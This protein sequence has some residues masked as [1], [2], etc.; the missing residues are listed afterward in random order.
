MG[1][2]KGVK[3]GYFL[4]LTCLSGT[5]FFIKFRQKSQKIGK[6]AKTRGAN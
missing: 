1:V 6:L 3:M 5:F 4:K 2:K